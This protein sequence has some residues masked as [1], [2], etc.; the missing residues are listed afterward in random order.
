MYLNGLKLVRQDGETLAY[1]FTS[2]GG[3]F[4]SILA[5]QA[6]PDQ[7]VLIR[8]AII[9]VLSDSPPELLRQ[10]ILYC[11]DDQGDNW[12]IERGSNRQRI[13]RNRD[14]I[15]F[16]TG[17]AKLR[18]ALSGLDFRQVK[19]DAECHEKLALSD[20][21]QIAQLRRENGH[22]LAELTPEDQSSEDRIFT[23]QLHQSLASELSF[24]TDF[25]QLDEKPELS[26]L[27]QLAP[28]LSQMIHQSEFIRQQL[29]QVNP[30][31]TAT[32][33]VRLDQLTKLKEELRILHHLE[34]LYEELHQPGRSP[35]VLKDRLQQI[36][37][38]IEFLCQDLPLS[39]KL[40][41][42]ADV[43]W[44]R[45][46]QILVRFKSYEQLERYFRL[47][48]NRAE[49]RYQP[50][51]DHYFD[52]IE[53]FIRS[54]RKILGEL[55]QALCSLTEY[56]QQS[57]TR[58]AEVPPSGWL[59]RLDQWF[60]RQQ[61]DQT[62]GSHAQDGEDEACDPLLENSRSI[63][64]QTLRLLGKLHSDAELSK[65]AN[66]ESLRE[67]QFK[68]EKVTR[69]YGKARDLWLKTAKALHLDPQMSLKSGMMLMQKIGE[70][71]RLQSEKVELTNSL[72]HY[73]SQLSL[74][75]EHLRT[76]YQVTGSAKDASLEQPS[77]LLRELKTIV[78]YRNE[79]KQQLDKLQ[80]QQFQHQS[81]SNQ[82]RGIVQLQRDLNYRWQQ[83][84]QVLGYVAP[85]I[86]NRNIKKLAAA[87]I[88]IASLHEVLK[89]QTPPVQWD[90][91]VANL[92]VDIP[93]TIVHT[94]FD[95][96]SREQKQ[97]FVSALRQVSSHACMLLLIHE[98][99]LLQPL[100][101]AGISVATE[102][103][104]T[105]ANRTGAV[106]KPKLEPAPGQ[107]SRKIISE[108]AAAAL[109]L[110]KARNV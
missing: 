78:S 89:H 9:T 106:A 15:P 104:L 26:R 10:V 37:D 69:E 58:K 14:E 55:E 68:L 67:I 7:L 108:R 24:I 8:R 17:F 5:L 63:V 82:M 39:H 95:G 1:K 31:R 102:V 2:P 3:R 65:Q 53:D 54:D 73:R 79:K 99:D 103:D 33:E 86:D 51:A 88:K 101:E 42:I 22:F 13:W 32:A 28:G 6:R 85:E 74:A 83:H 109:E 64:N 23:N 48:V 36:E 38:R 46:M 62:S 56:S 71:L 25:L 29:Q 44:D 110:F 45:F 50:I 35:G 59:R 61:A 18:L 30:T 93:L 72:N 4:R 12:I 60:D 16:E 76:W 87:I 97:E 11:S 47:T 107:E 40:T 91:F 27:V 105:K 43:D 80:Q 20:L 19:Q 57:Q 100:R 81:Q 34:T 84:F 21:V 92:S 52:C 49:N 98:Q 96:S 94:L 70:L 41:K 90:E 75:R 77:I 66:D